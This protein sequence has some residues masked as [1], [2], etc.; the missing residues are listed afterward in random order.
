MWHFVDPFLRACVA[1]GDIPA[2]AKQLGIDQGTLR[3]RRKDKGY[4]PMKP[5]RPKVRELSKFQHHVVDQLAKGKAVN[6][7]ASEAGV[8]SQSVSSARAKAEAKTAPDRNQCA[9]C[10]GTGVIGC[11]SEQD[12]DTFTQ[13]PRKRCKN[14]GPHNHMCPHCS[15]DGY[16]TQS[17]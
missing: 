1:P 10:E 2:L 7:I 15:G 11:G 3:K 14:I 8:T 16:T 12:L 13:E 5:G 9:P 6:E 4:K 17:H